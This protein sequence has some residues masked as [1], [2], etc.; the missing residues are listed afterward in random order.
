MTFLTD[1]SVFVESEKQNEFYE[2]ISP[3]EY[4]IL[5]SKQNDGIY[6]IRDHSNWSPEENIPDITVLP[7]IY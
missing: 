4:A 7:F 5:S 1:Y 2:Q 3:E 6:D